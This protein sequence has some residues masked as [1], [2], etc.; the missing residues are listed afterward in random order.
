MLILMVFAALAG[1][2]TALSPCVLPVLPF[3]VGGAAEPAFAAV[4]CSVRPSVLSGRR[5]PGRSSRQ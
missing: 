4:S 5:A 3:V 1:L 2:A